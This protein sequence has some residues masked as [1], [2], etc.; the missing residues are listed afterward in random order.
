MRRTVVDTNVYVDWLNYGL[1]SELLFQPDAVKFMSAVVLMELFAGA[2]A[3]K[4]RR[5]IA[6]LQAV[7][8]KAD[9]VVTPSETVLIEA[10]HTLRQLAEREGYSAASSR[11]LVQDVL[12]ALSARSI[13]ATVITQNARDFQAIARVRPFDFQIA[14]KRSPKAR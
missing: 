3:P 5:V 1:H 9:R 4:D 8:G 11:G 2:H 6:R 13:G 10:G 14:P 7:F 12:I